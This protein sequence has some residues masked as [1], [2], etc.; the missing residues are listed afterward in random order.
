MF[1]RFFS[2]DSGRHTQKVLTAAAFSLLFSFFFLFLFLPVYPLAA[3]NS[4][5]PNVPTLKDAEHSSGISETPAERPLFAPRDSESAET[6][7]VEAK[8]L[9]PAAGGNLKNLILAVAGVTFLFMVLI[10][11]LK[12]FTPGEAPVLPKD[13]FEILGKSP[14]AFRQQLYLM[15]CG[16]KLFVVS[17]SQ[18]GLDR[19]GEI[20]EEAEVARLSRLCGKPLAEIPDSI[21]D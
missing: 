1:S 6:S 4:S 12:K 15:R 11:I 16:K 21:E 18:N 8:P 3:Q 5:S 9:L 13:V 10:F 20:E 17:V 7:D 14:L 2:A 19:I